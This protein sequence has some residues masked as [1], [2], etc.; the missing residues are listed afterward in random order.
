MTDLP[1][2]PSAVPIRRRHVPAVLAVLALCGFTALPGPAQDAA[3]I[4]EAVLAHL[5]LHN[6]AHAPGENTAVCAGI[7]RGIGE[8]VDPD[9]ATLSRLREVSQPL[10]V[11][12]VSRCALG[13]LGDTRPDMRLVVIETGDPAIAIMAGP[14]TP[15][16]PDSATA[17]GSYYE[18]G[19]SGAVYDCAVTRTSNGWRVAEC[20]LVLIS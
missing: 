12:G 9:D 18:G 19:L 16:R 13:S 8:A 7:G 4:R 6:H 15:H 5:M 10:P 11:I 20:G 1:P 2:E 17:M 3:T 14:I